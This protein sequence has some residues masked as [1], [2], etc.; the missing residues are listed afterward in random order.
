LHLNGQLICQIPEEPKTHYIPK[1]PT[2]E[3]GPFDLYRLADIAH[4]IEVKA[5]IS[6][7]VWLKRRITQIE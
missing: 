1:Y 6:H 2:D 7:L 4:Q 3:T 5:D